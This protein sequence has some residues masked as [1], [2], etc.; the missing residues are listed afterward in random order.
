MQIVIPMSGFGE[1]F[2]RAGYTV[3][4]PLIEIDGKPVIAHII[5]LFPGE[6]DF[7][8]ICN[9]EHLENPTYKLRETLLRYAPKSKVL[10]IEPHRLGPVHALSRAFDQI[11]DAQ[12]VIVNYCDFTCYWNYEHFK[13]YVVE[14]NLDGC[15]PSYRGFHPHMLG[16]TNYAFIRDDHG[17]L[18]DIQEKKPFSDNRMQE[19]ASS[20]TFYFSSGALLKEYSSRC[21][22]RELRV[23][24][25]FYVSMIYK[26]MVE[27][28]K[29]V[30]VYE[31]QHFMQWGTPDDLAEYRYWSDT[32]RDLAAKP[33]PTTGFPGT[34]LLPMAGAGSRF[35]KE[36]YELPKPVIPVS[37]APMVVQAARDLPRMEKQVFV[38]RKDLDRLDLITEEIRRAFPRAEFVVLE[39]LT[40]GQARTCL[41]GMEGID[42]DQPLTIGAC[43]NGLIYDGERFTTLMADQDTDVIVWVARGYPGARLKPQMYGWVDAEGDVVRRVSVKVPLADPSRDPIIIGAFT[44]KRAADFGRCAEHLIA[45]N[46]RVNGEVY[47]DSCINDAL[48]LGLRCKILEIDRYL[49]WGTPDDLRSFEYWQSCF[50]KWKSHPYSIEADSR[51][52]SAARAALTKRYA[53]R[54]PKL[55]RG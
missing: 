14:N 47:V 53:E 44:F 18:L 48:E 38:V 15:L 37:G 11:D 39:A 50:S 31:L 34:L 23:N 45:S 7:I 42:R 9:R 29:R 54:L 32:F 5:D 2:R 40:D 3:P 30:A 10:A 16:P 22:E 21:I 17:M 33:R 24:D 41:L 19:Y 20:G 12:P 1:R 8:F 52:D 43:D 25:E 28:R 27:E 26:I 35:V 55:G 13:R 4:K 49:C 6:D 51:V 46:V 36:G